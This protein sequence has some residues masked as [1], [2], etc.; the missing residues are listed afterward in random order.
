M[1]TPQQCSGPWCTPAETW[2]AAAAAAALP[3]LQA[4]EQVSAAQADAEQQRK[5][6]AH[7]AE[8]ALLREGELQALRA[9]LKALH[10]VGAVW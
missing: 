1:L 9:E 6:A 2:I 4:H 7:H 8:V 10:K 5:A 3:L